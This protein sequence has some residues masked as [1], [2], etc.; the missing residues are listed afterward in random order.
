MTKSIRPTRTIK[1][2]DVDW[3]S[4][5]RTIITK[6]LPRNMTTFIVLG[7]WSQAGLGIVNMD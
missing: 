2:T 4:I 5:I 7:Y 6:V 3:V 1:T